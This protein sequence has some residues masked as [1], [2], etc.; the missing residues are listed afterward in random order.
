M[1][2]WHKTPRLPALTLLFYIHTK[3][4]QMTT[5][6]TKAQRQILIDWYIDCLIETESEFVDGSE[7]A[8]R[9]SL[10]SMNNSYFYEYVQEMMPNCMQDLAKMK[11]EVTV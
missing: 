2:N 5:F 3:Q 9:Q 7:E 10:A 11:Q 1:A 8:E 6:L 4:I